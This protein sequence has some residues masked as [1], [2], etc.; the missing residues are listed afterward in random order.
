[1]V[2]ATRM[3]AAQVIDELQALG[4]E[5]TRKIYRR[6][7][8][9]GDLYGVSY[10]DLGKLRKKVKTDHGLARQLWA[11]GNHDAR[12]LAMM[13]ADP[14]RAD[15]A[16]LDGWAG[17]LGNYVEADALS[18]YVAKTPFARE[19]G[20]AWIESPDESVATAGWNLLGQLAMHDRALPGEYFA[21]YLERIERDIHQA[22]NRVRYAMNNVLIAIGL[23]SAALEERAIAAAGRIGEV[24]VDHGQ[25]GCKTPDAATYIEKAAA[26]KK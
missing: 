9:R 12:I 16:T 10:G 14:A 8:V 2:T 18:G 13:I 15:S 21:P 26:R 19:K 25:T 3:T 4:K 24:V 1:M 11:T 17:D 20:E 6:H 23:H 7:G 22:Q 5:Q